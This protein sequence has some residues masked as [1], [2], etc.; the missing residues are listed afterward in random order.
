MAVSEFRRIRQQALQRVDA[1]LDFPRAGYSRAWE[2]D[3]ADRTRYANSA[4]RR[5]SPKS[6]EF[7]Y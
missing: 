7:V 6:A 2:I 3:A 1:E 5:M 4:S